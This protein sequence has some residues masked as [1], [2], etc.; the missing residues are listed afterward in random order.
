MTHAQMVEMERHRGQARM[1]AERTPADGR[2]LEVARR[3]GH[4]A[5]ELAKTGGYEVAVI[6]VDADAGSVEIVQANAR[7]AGVPVAVSS[8]DAAEL[9]YPDGSFDV[10]FCCA[11]FRD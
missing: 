9:P 3:S 5:I 10:V 8:G 2:I 1:V 6:D 11:A 4:T 7:E